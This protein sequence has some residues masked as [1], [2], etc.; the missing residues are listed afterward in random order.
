VPYATIIS[1]VVI[2]PLLYYYTL[3]VEKVKKTP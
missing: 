2:L 3:Q 1:G